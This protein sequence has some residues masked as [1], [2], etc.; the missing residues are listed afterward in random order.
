MVVRAASLSG[1]TRTPFA[2][3]AL[4]AALALSLAACSSSKEASPSASGSVTTGSYSSRE[5]DIGR[6]FAQCARD[7]G[8]PNFP[9]P[10]VDAGKIVWPATDGDATKD[11]SRAV[12]AL[13]ECKAI[14]DQLA[15]LGRHPNPSF[16][17]ADLPKLRD[18]AKCMRE[19][20]LP[21]FPDPRPDGT[22]KLSGTPLEGQGE[23][24]TFY[25]AIDACKH[26]YDKRIVTS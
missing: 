18:L 15:A 26:F 19:H 7:H 22:F 21:D 17:P 6:Q 4:L 25:N 10:V 24:E 14:G 5:L 1:M 2:V 20:G 16:D 3:V 11:Q 9:D 13:P 8:Y 12:A 23:T